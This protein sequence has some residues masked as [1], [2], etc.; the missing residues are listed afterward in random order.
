M[1][2]HQGWWCQGKGG[3][4]W[5]SQ[6]DVCLH[7]RSA[8]S[9]SSRRISEDLE[10]VHQVWIPPG[11]ENGNASV[12]QGKLIA[13][14]Q[15]AYLNINYDCRS[16]RRRLSSLS[17][18]TWNCWVTSVIWKSWKPV[19]SLIPTVLSWGLQRQKI[20]GQCTD[21]GQSWAMIARQTPSTPSIRIMLSTFLQRFL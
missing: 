6:H 21:L 5:T 18:I 19:E 16:T 20:L 1:Q 13:I 12:H 10:G 2:D 9:G 14:D 8:S 15:T 17:S 3:R 4:V 7:H 11:R